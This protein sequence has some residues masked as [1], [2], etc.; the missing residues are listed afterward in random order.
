MD[1]EPAIDQVEDPVVGE[2][3]T[4]VERRLVA[5][6]VRERGLGHLDDE[7]GRVWMFR[8]MLARAPADDGDIRL[9]FVV[10]VDRQRVLHANGVFVAEDAAQD[11]GAE[12]DRAGVDGALRTHGDDPPADELEVLVFAEDPRTDHVLVVPPREVARLTLH[13]AIVPRDQLLPREAP[14]HQRR[15]WPQATAPTTVIAN[16]RPL[17]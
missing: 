17:K 7:D 2:A 16:G 12:I 3:G 15:F 5:A 1:L 9:R 4:R 8:E 6:V 13:A 10:E 14:E 11:L